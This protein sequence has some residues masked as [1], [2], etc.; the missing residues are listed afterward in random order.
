MS[1]IGPEVHNNKID[2]ND[3]QMN[4]LSYDLSEASNFEESN[5]PGNE[6]IYTHDEHGQIGED[7]F[8]SNLNSKEGV[9]KLKLYI[10][11][12]MVPLM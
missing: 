4:R 7:L 8:N 12:R 10:L 9:K 11:P 1:S 3:A 6:I 2:L 5:F